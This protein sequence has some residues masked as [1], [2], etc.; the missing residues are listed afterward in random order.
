MWCRLVSDRAGNKYKPSYAWWRTLRTYSLR[1]GTFDAPTRSRA[2]RT[3]LQDALND[4]FESTR[5]QLR[6]EIEGLANTHA[7]ECNDDQAAVESDISTSRASST[8]N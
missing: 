5:R 2:L 4:A 3:A 6:L 7:D 1:P 8:Q